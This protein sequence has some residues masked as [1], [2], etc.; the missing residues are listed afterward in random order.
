[1]KRKDAA[2]QL[3]D[4][5]TIVTLIPLGL[6]TWIIYLMLGV[7]WGVLFGAFSGYVFYLSVAVC[8]GESDQSE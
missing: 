3:A 2:R 1:M 8:S 5:L 4:V 6:F 7:F